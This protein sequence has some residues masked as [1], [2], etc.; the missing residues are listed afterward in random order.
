MEE[1]IKKA[2]AEYLKLPKA[3]IRGEN[4]SAEMYKEHWCV[5][6]GRSFC[7]PNPH[8]HYTLIEFAFWLGKNQSL[9]KRFMSN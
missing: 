1:D 7:H 4:K 3:T 9:H 6:T 2:Y 5:F 8:R